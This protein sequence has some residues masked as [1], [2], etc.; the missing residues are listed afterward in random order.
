MASKR[1]K[2]RNPAQAAEQQVT[3]AAEEQF[4]KDVQAIKDSIPHTEN[5]EPTKEELAT[6]SVVAEDPGVATEDRAAAAAML[7]AAKALSNTSAQTLGVQEPPAEPA[8]PVGVIIR[9]GGIPVTELPRYIARKG[10]EA[11]KPVPKEYAAVRYVP[12]KAF[13]ARA[14][15]NA[16]WAEKAIA[17]ASRPGGATGQEIHEAGVPVH[18]LDYFVRKTGWLRAAPVAAAQPSTEPEAPESEAATSPVLSTAGAMRGL[19]DLMEDQ[20]EEEHA[21]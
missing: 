6:D 18:T 8:A 12:G 11:D 7:A 3:N 16:A 4:A 13:K 19:E 15:H 9:H 5:D 17:L 21:E 1:N 14:S 2:N 10:A 20:P